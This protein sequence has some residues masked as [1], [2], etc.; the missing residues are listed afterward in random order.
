MAAKTERQTSKQR[1]FNRLVTSHDFTIVTETHGSE[2]KALAFRLPDGYV[3]YWSHSSLKS[4]GTGIILS[5]NFLSRFSSDVDFAEVVPGRLARIKL[6]GPEGAVDIWAIY[7]HTGVTPSE[8]RV[9]RAGVRKA[10]E[11]KIADFNTSLTIIAGDWNFVTHRS[12]RWCNTAVDW[13]GDRDRL[14]FEEFRDSLFI[15]NMLN[16]LHQEHHTYY[17]TTATSRLDRIYTN[18]HISEQLDHG[19]G[20]STLRRDNTISK[21]SPVSFFRVSLP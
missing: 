17:S 11:P 5:Q 15:P 20:C 18:H 3:A 10:L 6:I 1:Y 9:A 16:E 8:D 4:A 2:G 12:D 14:E 7:M 13:T 21:H 19:F